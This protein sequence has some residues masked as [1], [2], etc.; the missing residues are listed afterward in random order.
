MKRRTPP[1]CRRGP[2]PRQRGLSLVETL[3]G[4]AV[5]LFIVGGAMKLFVANLDAHRRLLV[6]TRV[7]QDLRASA[8]L[9]ARDLRRAGYWEQAASGV[10]QADGVSPTLNPHALA[11]A[12]GGLAYTYDK[13][14][15]DVYSAGFRLSE[16]RIQLRT[17][18]ATWQDV[19]DPAVLRVTR[20]SI[21]PA[22]REV[23]LLSRCAVAICPAG[24]TACP[25]RLLIRH[26]D[27][28]LQAQAVADAQVQREIR[29]S[30]R[31]RNDQLIGQC[32][33]P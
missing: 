33:T 7:H 9:I 26:Y 8:D 17:A 28:T 13:D 11:E 3:I 18:A 2:A 29:E 5:G 24:S 22:L 14:A 4:L 25:P 1:A 19:T 21:A 20:L 31:V 32:P 23:S 27:L 16:G 12:A 30:V 6:E 10:W 15:G